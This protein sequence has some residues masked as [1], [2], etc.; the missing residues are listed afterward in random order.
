MNF[1]FSITSSLVVPVSL[2]F[3]MGF[4][5]TRTV[6]ASATHTV[7]NVLCRTAAYADMRRSSNSYS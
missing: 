3:E 5:N 1:V 7:Y 4:M 2:K 6:L